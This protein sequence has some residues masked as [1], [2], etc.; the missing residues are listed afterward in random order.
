[1]NGAPQVARVV[2]VIVGIWLFIS[3]FVLPHTY[4][5]F[6]NTWILGILTVVF[7]LVAVRFAPVRY[8]NTLLAIWLFISAFALSG[9]FYGT[10]WNN[11]IVAIVIF[12]ISLIPAGRTEALPAGRSAAATDE[13]AIRPPQ[14]PRTV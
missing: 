11:A 13:S 1:M 3:A 7:A 9:N 12:V 10:V 2:N 8:L 5:Q 4:A 14:Q 6:T